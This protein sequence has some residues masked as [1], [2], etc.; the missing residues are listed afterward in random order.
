MER[1]WMKDIRRSK[2][3]T[4]AELAAK[5]GMSECHLVNIENGKRK[6]NGLDMDFLIRLA[7]AL[8]VKPVKILQSEIDY[9][10]EVR[11]GTENP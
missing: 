1:E 5:V 9:L 10:R 7:D 8:R 11:D 6:T 4:C 3:M 2:G